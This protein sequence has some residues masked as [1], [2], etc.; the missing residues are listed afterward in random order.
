MSRFSNLS[1]TRKSL[2]GALLAFVVLMAAVSLS[3]VSSSSRRSLTVLLLALEL[4]LGGALAVFTQTGPYVVR[5]RTGRLTASA[6][7]LSAPDM[8]DAEDELL[9][10]LRMIGTLCE[11]ET[12]VLA[13]DSGGSLTAHGRPV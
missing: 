12:F 1:L 4:W 3:G 10:V 11:V 2:V 7:S 5:I 6:T 13:V 8:I 9:G